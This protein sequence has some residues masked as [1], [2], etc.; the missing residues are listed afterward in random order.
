MAL[1]P[2]SPPKWLSQPP[3]AFDIVTAYFPESKPKGALR[4]RPCLVLDV[5]RGKDSGMIG[6]RIAFGT[7]NLK[8]VQRQHLDLIVQN[9]ADLNAMGLPMATRFDLDA[10][11]IVTLPWTQ[12]FFGC[13]FGYHHP[14]LCSLPE[15][16]VK[17]YFYIM[18]LRQ[19]N[20][21]R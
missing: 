16:Y 2:T 5:L 12:E 4:L 11:N 10:K 19:A 13:W 15:N 21:E 17:S 6:C 20:D 1:E 9:N 14:G 3:S 18:A 7:K 8:F